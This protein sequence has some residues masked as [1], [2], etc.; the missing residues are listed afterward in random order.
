MHFSISNRDTA[1]I[2]PFRIT[3]QI[4]WLYDFKEKND[5]QLSEKALMTFLKFQ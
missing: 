1:G 4:G 3:R 5:D 2:I